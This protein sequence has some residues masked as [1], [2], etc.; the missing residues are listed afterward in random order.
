MLTTLDIVHEKKIRWIAQWVY[1]SM[2]A[3]VDEHINRRQKAEFL[4]Q[5]TDQSTLKE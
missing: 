1:E 2:C 5:R 3:F 4:F